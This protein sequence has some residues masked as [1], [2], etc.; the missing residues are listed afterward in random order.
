MA[1]FLI[2]LAVSEK[3]EKTMK[4]RDR[5]Q[6]V[7]QKLS[8][9]TKPT[10]LRDLLHE[11]GK[12][13]PERSVRR[14]LNE[15]TNEGVI[16]KLGHKRGTKYRVIQNFNKKQEIS[17]CFGSDSVSAIEYVRRPL[18]ERQPIA[19]NEKWFDAYKPNKTFYFSKSFREQLHKAGKRSQNKDPAGTYA[20]QIFNRLLIDL[21][22]NSSR[23]EGNTYSLLDTEKLILE[24]KS[25]EGKLSQESV[26]ILNHKEA[27]RYL[28]DTVHRLNIS[29]ETIYTLHYLLAEGLVESKYAGKTRD[30]GVRIV[31]STYIPFENPKYLNKQLQRIA[32]KAAKIK[33]S[34]EQSLFLLVHISY[35]QTFLDAN[36][37]TARLS[38]NIP[39]IM[40]NLVPLSFNDVDRD[41]YMSATIAIYE[42]Q[43]VH[44]IIDLYFF[45]YMR[46]CVAYDST[47]KAMGYDEVRVRYRQKRRSI[48][49]EIIIRKLVGKHLKSYIESKAKTEISKKD[50]KAFL[51]DIM[52]DL[53][54]MDQNRIAGLGVTPD[55]LDS[56]LKIYRSV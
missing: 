42:L 23:L 25:A 52:E 49:R 24:G 8:Q 44:P 39:L 37:R 54:E 36:K 56:W 26:M 15:L 12:N 16:E 1:V 53:E 45:S 10:S 27:I 28:V 51:E 19:Y 21:S 3:K 18:Y 14:W 33:D 4:F 48:I 6:A 34:F 43:E 35:I 7:L 2:K 47:I 50:Q 22:Y 55:E 32:E 17:S 9:K 38:A 5:K 41:D 20:H 40:N 29:K 30:Y 13:Y 11:L 46:T 31:G